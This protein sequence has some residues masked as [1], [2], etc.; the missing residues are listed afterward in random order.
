[1]PSGESRRLSIARHRDRACKLDP[2]ARRAAVPQTWRRYESRFDGAPQGT[3][4]FASAFLDILWSHQSA[5]FYRLSSYC[6]HLACSRICNIKP[7]KWKRHPNKSPSPARPTSGA[8]P[9]EAQA[10]KRSGLGGGA[11]RTHASHTSL[12]EQRSLRSMRSVHRQVS[13]DR[14]T[15]MSSHNLGFRLHRP[16]T[17]AILSR[18]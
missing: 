8:C 14:H 4:G 18:S 13:H 11:T 17:A 9:T 1:M 16:R 3:H 2:D 12:V 10:P 6:R 7:P 5:R 15:V